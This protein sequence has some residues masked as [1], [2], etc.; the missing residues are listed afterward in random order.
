ML[1]REDE[2]ML[3]VCGSCIELSL[4]G[5]ACDAADN[6]KDKSAIFL[7]FIVFPKIYFLAYNPR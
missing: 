1:G 7:K 5:K 3:L 6:I 4:R 2:A